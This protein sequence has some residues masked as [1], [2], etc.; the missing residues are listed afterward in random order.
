MRV[1]VVVVVSLLG[2]GSMLSSI[3]AEATFISYDFVLTVESASNC[4]PGLP[5]EAL[6]C[7]K[8]GDQFFGSFET[9]TDVSGFAD[10]VYP[11]IPLHSWIL[12]IGDVIWDMLSPYPESV[13]KGFRDPL[14][15]GINPGLIVAG[16]TITGFFGG[17][18]GAGDVPFVDFDY[19][20]GPGRFS[21][22]S[23]V[24]LDGTYVVHAVPEPVTSGLLI[25]GLAVLAIVGRSRKESWWAVRESNARPTD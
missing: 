21:A 23:G 17:V 8:P 11:L 19:I 20:A 5:P 4:A 24:R 3:A 7:A 10:G 25:I 9:T 22:L 13:F 18:Y 16:G 12:Q 2:I 1:R 6:P 14:L 15:G